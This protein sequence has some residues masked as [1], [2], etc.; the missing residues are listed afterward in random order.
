LSGSFR[1]VA[2]K[3]LGRCWEISWDSSRGGTRTR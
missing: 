3:L 1:Q 2:G